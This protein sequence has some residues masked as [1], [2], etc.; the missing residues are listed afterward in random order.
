L[1]VNLFPPSEDVRLGAELDREIRANTRQYRIL[2]HPQAQQYVQ[3]IVDRI[4][5]A[6]DIRYRGT[7]AYRVTLLQ[8]A[9]LAGVCPDFSVQ[10]GTEPDILRGREEID[11]HTCR[12][13]QCSDERK[14]TP[15]EA[16][17]E[18]HKRTPSDSG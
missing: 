8:D 1:E 7:F 11:L 12:Q 3:S 18:S 13:A 4:I 5:A 6:P 9:V 17:S 14:C 2:Q 10:L 15:H 16:F